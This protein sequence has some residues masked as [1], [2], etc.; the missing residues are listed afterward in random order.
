MPNDT[1]DKYT[2]NRRPF[3]T[4]GMPLTVRLT[5]YH[6]PKKPIYYPVFPLLWNDE[7]L[8][9]EQQAKDFG[10]YFV[11]AHH[12]LLTDY[13][14]RDGDTLPV[15]LDEHVGLW[16]KICHGAMR[17]ERWNHATFAYE[18]G[19]TAKAL[20]V[21]L[22]RLEDA[23]LLHRELCPNMQGR[24]IDLVPH[25]PRT[26]G[27]LKAGERK[28]LLK[29]VKTEFTR[30]RR[31]KLGAAWPGCTRD[32]PMMLAA[33]KGEGNFK[34]LKKVLNI[35]VWI[36]NQYQEEPLTTTKFVDE[37][38]RLCVYEGVEYNDK[39]LR[40]ACAMRRSVEEE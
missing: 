39:L 4:E 27:E 25:M 2:K 5:N 10:D 11:K 36:D 15:I 35:V 30:H 32:L 3:A 8:R 21:R 19:I 31:K 18:C 26:S 9:A 38:K 29:R 17:K 16:L 37:V 7:L 33:I 13:A 20:R 14:M 6:N 1:E 22:D 34:A 24:P 12:V 40:T 28:R 23:E